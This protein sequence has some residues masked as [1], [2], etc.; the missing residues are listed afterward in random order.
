MDV[1]Y[2]ELMQHY[3]NAPHKNV[4][5]LVT[6]EARVYSNTGKKETSLG[7]RPKTNLSMDWLSVSHVGSNIR[8]LGMRLERNIGGRLMECG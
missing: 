6:T 7:P 3:C 1:G 2:H 5:V 8:G 4:A